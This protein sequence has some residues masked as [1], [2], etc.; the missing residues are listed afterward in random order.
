MTLSHDLESKT[1]APDGQDPNVH[2]SSDA[3]TSLMSR[4]IEFRGVEQG[5]SGQP[6]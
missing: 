1:A 5:V 4:L 6:A 3:L 2:Q